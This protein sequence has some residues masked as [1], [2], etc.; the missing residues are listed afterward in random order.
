MVKQNSDAPSADLVV[1]G[2]GVKGIGLVGAL[3][4]LAENGY[5]FQRV[6]GTSAGAVVGSL[7][8]AGMPPQ[9]V[10]EVMEAVDF[11]RFKDRDL[12][13]KVPLAGP[14]LSLVLERGIYEGEYL[15]EWLGNELAELGVETFAD[16]ALDDPDA[17]LDADQQFRLVVMA[18]DI[19]R[20]ELLRLPW[21]YRRVFG[22]EPGRQR[23]VDA[24]RTSM[25][26]PFFFE[27]V[28]LANTDNGQVSTLV[29]G[30]VL[31]NFPIDTFDR[32][33]DRPPRWP[34][35]GI[36]LL[37][38]LPAALARLLPFGALP[39]PGLVKMLEQLVSTMS[40]GHDQ[41]QLSLPWV[42]A[43]TIRVDTDHVGIVD[44]NLSHADEE[45]L[46]DNGRAAATDFLTGWNWD[47][48]QKK[49]RR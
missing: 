8:A 19:T 36:K 49:Y 20:G 25:S 26:I 46:Y 9:R 11:R 22:L 44:F 39:M 37:P 5:Q 21:D 30:G 12:L 14:A 35:F 45:L 43:R 27:P 6:A 40:V 18:T 16:M 31:S 10:H 2:G 23:V 41:A 33:D 4:V 7:I 17:S 15:K 32:T 3:C 13:D 47:D 29:D 38:Q 24:V 28:T 1:E 42:A 34:T 48:Y